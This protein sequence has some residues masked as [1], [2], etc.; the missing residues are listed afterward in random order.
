MALYRTDDGGGDIGELLQVWVDPEYRGQGVATGILD[1][2]FEWA[3]RNG[4]GA[5][6]ATVALGNGE[7]LR[8]YEKSGF[9]PASAN[10]ADAPD[11]RVLTKDISASSQRRARVLAGEPGYRRRKDGVWQAV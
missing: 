4:F 10:R 7:A 11:G 8:F 9:V 1:A 2:V 5:I 6:I 3:G